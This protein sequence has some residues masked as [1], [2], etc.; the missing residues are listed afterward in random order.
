MASD[1]GRISSD[2]IKTGAMQPK[3]VLEFPKGQLPK[4]WLVDLR[5]TPQHAHGPVIFGVEATE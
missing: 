5:Y 1:I 4:S 3:P 2:Q